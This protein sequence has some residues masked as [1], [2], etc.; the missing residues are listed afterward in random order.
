VTYCNLPSNIVGPYNQVLFLGC[1]VSNFNC[2]LG[3]GAEQSTLNVS[4]AEDDCF[5]PQS[6][7]YGEVDSKLSTLSQQPQDVGGGTAF[8]KIGESYT[9]ND[10]TK[11]L[12]KNMAFQMQDLETARDV[13]NINLPSNLKDFGKICYDINGNIVYWRDRDPKFIGLDNRFAPRGDNIVGGFDI[14]GVPVRFK[15]NNFTFGGLVSSWKQNGSQGGVRLFDVEIKSF[16]SLLNGCQLIIDKYAGTICGIVPNTNNNPTNQN[17]A[18]PLPYSVDVTTTPPTFNY[19]PYNANINQ[20]NIPNVFNIYGY[21]EYLGYKNKQ[22]GNASVNDDGMRAQYIYDALIALLDP[23]KDND[24]ENKNPFSPYG[25]IIAR[26]PRYNTTANPVDFN[27]TISS[28]SS[29]ISLIHMGLCKDVVS[30]DTYRR[31]R[32]KLDLSEVPRPPKWLRLQGPVISIMQFITE[33]CD[34]TGHDFFIDF[35]TSNDPNISGIIKIRTISRRKQPKKDQIQALIDYYANTVGVNSY[36]KG[37]EFTD[38]NTRTMYIGG[39]QK[40]LLQLKCSRLSEKQNTLIYDPWANNGNGALINYDQRSSLASMPNQMRVPN[41]AS[42]RRYSTKVLGGAAVADASINFEQPVYFVDGSDSRQIKRG[43]YYDAVNLGESQG[44]LGSIGAIG[45]NI[46]LDQDNICPYF[47]VGANGLIRPV[48]FDKKMGQMQI[49]FQTAD[50]QHLTSLPLMAY[51]TVSVGIGSSVS[52]PIFLVLENEIRAAGGGFQSWLKYCFTNIFTTDISEIIYKGFRD[53]YGWQGPTNQEYIKGLFDLQDIAFRK[54]QIVN[55]RPMQVSL[56]HLNPRFASLYKD[57]TNIHKFFANIANEYY[58]KKYMVRIPEVAWYRDLSPA[59]DNNNQPIILGTDENNMPIY[60]YE[61]SGKIFANYSISVDG[62]WEEPGNFIDDTLIVGGTRLSSIADESGK[63][64]CII[65]FNASMEKD[66][67]RL[68]NRQQLLASAAQFNFSDNVNTHLVTD[69]VAIMQYSLS[70]NE[71]NNENHYFMSLQHNLPPEEFVTLQYIAPTVNMSMAHGLSVSNDKKY[72][73]YTKA[74][75]DQNIEFLSPNFTN[76]RAIVSISS[77]VLLGQDKNLTETN[78]ISMMGQDSLLRVTQG[79]SVPTILQSLTIG[80]LNL[81]SGSTT[82]FGGLGP[83]PAHTFRNN[84]N[85]PITMASFDIVK[86]RLMQWHAGSNARL[87]SDNSYVDGGVDPVLRKA[88]IPLFCALPIELNTAIYGPWINHPGLIRSNIFPDSNDADIQQLE[89]ENLVGGVKVNVDESLVPWNYGG[90]TFL[91][92]AVMLK[93]A[94]EVNYQQTLETGTVQI[95]G[96]DNMS[97]GHMIRYY[98]QTFDGPILN[99]IQVQIGQN[100]IITTY[101]FRT[102]TRKLGL[103]NK[104]SSE[105]IKAIGQESLKRNKEINTQLLKLSSKINGFRVL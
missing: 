79:A 54:T 35:Q 22:Y 44:F 2:N 83:N 24:P 1:S 19:Y 73:L 92:E 20:G 102:Y 64:P 68:W 56:D 104:E 93:I 28:D 47:G 71:L 77:P 43:N 33:I 17:I 31:C 103:F 7:E 51:N 36:S 50:I 49:I 11:A 105:R 76:P 94:E 6:N 46:K 58:G 26:S 81:F 99:S 70:D 52:S 88:A 87:T 67:S 38:T 13:E 82:L 39:K 72:K 85:T 97:L 53:K 5:H 30:I 63:L 66:N 15:F 69:W 21:L 100:G 96:F 65:G 95:P 90:M 48:H 75:P 10:P 91:D 34:G 3:W 41:P 40:R 25:A 98:G 37:K 89:I 84:D 61:G 27:S 12:H 59:I 16:A 4:L 23:S 42:V 80:A 62:A 55:G 78:V 60:A 86:K 18:V 8:K 74:T 9:T 57:L 29:A 14:L 101:N 32:L 45:Q